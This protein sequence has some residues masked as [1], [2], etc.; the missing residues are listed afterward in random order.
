MNTASA[1]VLLAL[2][3]ALH[4]HAAP[5]T[6]NQQAKLSLGAARIEREVVYGQAGGVALPMDLYFPDH[7]SEPA[8]PVVLYVHGG[9]WVMGDKSMVL[10]MAGP[11]ELVRRGYVVAAINYRLGSEHLFPAMI[12]DVKCAVRFLRAHAKVFSLD[13]E[14]IGVMGDSAGGQLVSLLG[15]TGDSAEFDGS[16]GWSH[17]SARVQAVADLYGP[18]DFNAPSASKSFMSR[19]ILKAAF[20]TNAKDAPILKQASPINHVTTNA[21]PFLIVHGDHDTMVQLKQSENLNAA[22]QAAGSSSTLLVVTNYSHGFTPW[23]LKASPDPE[24]LAKVI[25]DFFDRTLRRR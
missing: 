25:A 11:A 19:R 9:G 3:L 21:P 1:A 13:P 7:V 23:R 5:S 15:L 8:M 4:T 24:A 6:T 22:L 14:R 16:G 12:E 18:T 2:L 17:F 20:G 10:A